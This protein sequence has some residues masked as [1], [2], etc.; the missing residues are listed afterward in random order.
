MG[1]AVGNRPAAILVRLS[2]CVDLGL[3]LPLMEFR[4]EGLSLGRLVASVEAARDAGFAAISANDH[5]LF[6]TPWLDGPTALASVVDRSGKMT[7]ATTIALAVLR[8]PVPLAKAL[9]AID[10]LSEGR[11][12][13]GVGPGSSARDYEAIGVPFEERWQRLDESILTLR[14]LLNG[15]PPPPA[16]FYTSPEQ[17]LEPRPAQEL[18]VPIWIGSWGSRAGLRRVARLGD[19]WLASAY[20]TSPDLFSAGRE[21][22]EGELEAV[23][24][25]ER[26]LPNALATMW[27]WVTRDEGEAE[28]VLTDLLAPLL[29]REAG[30]LRDQLC[31]GPPS[32]IIELLCRY[33]EAGCERVYIWPLGEERL[34]IQRLAE[35]VMPGLP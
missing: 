20:N 16:G 4:N 7:L 31:V 24:R 22:L 29:R 11:L 34:Q 23:G 30:E 21:L 28:R 2:A 10:L 27:T 33:E 5:F 19:G 3:H 26:E 6:S 15:E 32:R 14:A 9:A 8:G 13:A 18:G 17:E 1:I 12:I 35:E 25:A